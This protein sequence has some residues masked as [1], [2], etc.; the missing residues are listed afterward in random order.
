MREA[1]V[2]KRHRNRRSAGAERRKMILVSLL[3]FAVLLTAVFGM[4]SEKAK[5]NTEKKY[6]YYTSYEVQPGDSLWTIA[7][8]YCDE[9]EY[10][11]L[12]DYIDEVCEINHLTDDNLIYAGRNLC[13]PYY[14]DEYK[15]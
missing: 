4:T 15:E 6:K 5:A 1:D 11:S 9:D 2:Q 7:E 8:Q 14:S 13:I 12:G 10:G 3:L